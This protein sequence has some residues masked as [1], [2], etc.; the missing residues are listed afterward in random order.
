[1]KNLTDYIIL[2]TFN[3][4]I[5]VVQTAVSHE[6]HGPAINYF[7]I[8]LFSEQVFRMYVRG[9]EAIAVTFSFIFV[10]RVIHCGRHEKIEKKD[11]KFPSNIAERTSIKQ[12]IIKAP[13]RNDLRERSENESKFPFIYFLKTQNCIFSNKIIAV[14]K[15][16]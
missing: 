1:M 9:P 3:K 10:S 16:S 5:D 15:S 4:Y 8:V 14:T 11:E 6:E 7:L 12:K 2:I 13:Q